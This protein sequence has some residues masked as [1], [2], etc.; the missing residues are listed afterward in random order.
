[1]DMEEYDTVLLKVVI[2]K[3]EVAVYVQH[4]VE[5]KN[6]KQMDVK[7]YREKEDCAV[8]ITISR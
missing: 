3:I 4:M 7:S 1:M 2:R 6:A 8:N 5:E